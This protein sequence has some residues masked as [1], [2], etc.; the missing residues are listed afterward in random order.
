VQQQ[1]QIIILDLVHIWQVRASSAENCVSIVPAVNLGGFYQ[2]VSK[3]LLWVSQI[4]NRYREQ[5]SSI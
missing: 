1:A 4:L 3:F 5:Q 2:A